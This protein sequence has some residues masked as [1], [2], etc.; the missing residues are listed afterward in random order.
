MLVLAGSYRR[1]GSGRWLFASAR[2]EWLQILIGLYV[3]GAVWEFAEARASAAIERGAGAGG[4]C[5]TGSPYPES[6]N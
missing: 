3:V 6:S 2:P 1:R 4:S 5:P